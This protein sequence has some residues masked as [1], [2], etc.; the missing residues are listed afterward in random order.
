MIG[1]FRAGH[2]FDAA[3]PLP[4]SE[5]LWPIERLR[6]GQR[7]HSPH[8]TTAALPRAGA[9]DLLRPLRLLNNGPKP[10]WGCRH[11]ERGD[12]KRRKRV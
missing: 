1:Y 2:A 3:E 8:C 11:V 9:D 10:L 6:S 5:A 12:T 7:G 4:V